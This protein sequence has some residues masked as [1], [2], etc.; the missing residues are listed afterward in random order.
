MPG[1]DVDSLNK[2]KVGICSDDTEHVL[3]ITEISCRLY[4]YMYLHVFHLKYTR[5][6]KSNDW[7]TRYKPSICDYVCYV[8]CNKLVYLNICRISF[9]HFVHLII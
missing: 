7:I 6:I 1:T 3:L 5:Q 2:L 4:T 9:F 8:W